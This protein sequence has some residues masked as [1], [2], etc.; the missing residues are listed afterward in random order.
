MS[1]LEV[2]DRFK[3]AK[4]GSQKPEVEGLPLCWENLQTKACPRCG[5]SLEDFEHISMWRCGCGFNISH[6][7]LDDLVRRIEDEEQVG[8][9]SWGFNRWTD[10]PP[11]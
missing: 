3:E 4:E 8:R 9:D 1:F 6:Y 11:F 2:G 5:D 10:M 7:K